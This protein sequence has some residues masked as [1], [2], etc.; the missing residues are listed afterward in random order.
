MTGEAT[1]LIAPGLRDHVPQ[2]WQNSPGLAAAGAR[3][4]TPIGRD[5]LDCLARIEAIE[6]AAARIDGPII[7]V[8]HSGGV[9]A[10]LHWAR[11][12]RRAVHGALLATPADFDQ[13]S[14]EG[15][16]SMEELGDGGW[17]PAPRNALRFSLHRR[18]QPH[19]SSRLIQSHC[20]VC[21]IMGQQVS[22]PPRGRPPQSR[23]R[24]RR[25]AARRSPDQRTR[26]SSRFALLA[27]ATP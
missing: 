11:L 19:Q 9:I 6:E 22:R 2:H 13:P 16:P 4:V 17:L 26:C 24:L 5:D 3:S 21:A 1:V 14:P 25:M 12:T 10:V 18:S 27:E 7:L 15:Y 20:D 23:I 8:A